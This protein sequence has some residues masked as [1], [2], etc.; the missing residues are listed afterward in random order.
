MIFLSSSPFH[1]TNRKWITCVKVLLY[2]SI[3]YV[4]NI[5]YLCVLISHNQYKNIIV[6]ILFILLFLKLRSYWYA[7]NGGD[8]LLLRRWLLGRVIKYMLLEESFSW[9]V[10]QS[11]L[12]DIV[13]LNC[14]ECMLWL[15]KT[16]DL[17][18]HYGSATQFVRLETVKDVMI[19]VDVG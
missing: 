5:C 11:C 6:W 18:F 7:S 13:V 2:F 16:L 9:R 3:Y 8:A 4:R 1:R 12:D 17:Q 10:G 14:R 15:V 19:I